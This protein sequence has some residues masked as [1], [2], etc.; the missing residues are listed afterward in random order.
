M[1]TQDKKR[2]TETI[3]EEIGEYL[4]AKHTK[5]VTGALAKSLAE[6]DVSYI[7]DAYS[8]ADDD[9]LKTFISAKKIEGLSPKTLNRYSYILEKALNSIGAPVSRITPD[10]IRDYLAS[11][12]QRGLSLRS[13]EGVRE[14][15]STFFRWVFQEGLISKNPMGNVGVIKYRHEIKTA[16]SDLE[17]NAIKRACK[18]KKETALVLFLEATG[19]RVGEVC[20]LRRGDV[21]FQNLEVKVLG[22]GNKERI[23]YMNEVAAEALKTYLASRSD[24][25]DCL[26][27]SIFGEMAEGGVRYILGQIG[28]RSGVENVHPHR[29]RRTLATRLINRGMPIQEVAFILGHANINTTMTY[30]CVDQHNVKGAYHKY[31]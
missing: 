13:L 25:K 1:T 16:F 10:D 17:L 9:V 7:G 18:N 2:L 27:A 26:F 19:C 23:V 29:F 12:Q 14:V 6:Y 3:E 11:E 5:M 22:K 31:I 24:N 4:T 8:A 21:D 15:M 28:E 30:V 20:R